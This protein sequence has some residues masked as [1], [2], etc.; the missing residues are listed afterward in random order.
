LIYQEASEV[1][2]K[3]NNILP[4]EPQELRKAVSQD[5]QWIYFVQHLELV[6]IRKACWLPGSSV[7]PLQRIMKLPCN[8]ATEIRH[9]CLRC[10][11]SDD[12]SLSQG[13]QDG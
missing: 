4:W 13:V 10:Q 7:D 5:Q 2:F 3:V 1:L 11:G 8:A 6:N 9:R 12:A